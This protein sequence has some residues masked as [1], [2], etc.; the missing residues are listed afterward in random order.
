M[1]ADNTTLVLFFNGFEPGKESRVFSPMTTT[2][3]LVVFLKKAISKGRLNNKP[4]LFP[5]PKLRSALSISISL[6]ILD[7]YGDLFFQCL[8]FVSF[9]SEILD[10]EVIEVLNVFV[11]D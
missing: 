5:M 10:L 4:F 3:P 2:C 6:C 8:V 9:Q 1:S 11:H 7:S